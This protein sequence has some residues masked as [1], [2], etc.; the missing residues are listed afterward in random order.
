MGMYVDKKLGAFDALMLLVTGVL[1]ADSIASSASAGVPSLTWWVILGICYMLPMGA[2][3]GELSQKYPAE[4]GIYVWVTKGLGPKW[5]ALTG[6][7]SF[8]C[9]LFIPTS[10]FIL[11]SDVFFS[12]FFPAVS[13]AG[14]I[15]LAIALVWLLGIVTSLP[16]VESQWVNNVAGVIKI[17]LY[18]GCLAAGIAF[19]ASGNAPANDFSIQS[20][21]P[22]PS[23]GLMF[24]PV[25]LYCCTGTELASASAEQMDEPA[26][27][28]PRIVFLM[29]V[30]N[31]VFNIIAGLGMLLVL[32]ADGIDLDLGLLDVFAA[33]IGRGPL[34][35]LI[36]FAFLFSLFAQTTTWVVGGDRGACES[37]KA[38]D[39]PAFL[40]YEKN[41]Q[42]MGAILTVCVASTVLL[43]VYGIF[44]NTASELFFSLL[45]CGVMATLL[46]YVFMIA[47]YHRLK[48]AGTLGTEGFHCPGGYGLSIFLQVLQCLTLLLLIYVP[49]YGWNDAVATNALGAVIMIGTGALVIA[50]TSGE[51]AAR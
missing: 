15:G 38:G 37:A 16:M 46:P 19:V 21:T 22:T 30:L 44:A 42:P 9:G 2:I 31:V 41:N 26:R 11:I 29:A 6:W 50:A 33:V 27:M 3:I 48:R 23:Q 25:I 4:G 28:L 7:L 35:Y 49:G 8:S 12:T 51:K 18:L 34:Y 5:G 1:F 10:C 20:L 47:S 39:L 43:V 17:V 14:R 24:L 32:P 13:L 36:V 45:S 40:G